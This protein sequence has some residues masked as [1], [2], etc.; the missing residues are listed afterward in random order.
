MAVEHLTAVVGA[1]ISEFKRKMAEVNAIARNAAREITAQVDAN[2]KPFQRAIAKVWAMARALDG[3]TIRVNVMTRVDRFERDL[4]D[5]ASAIRTFGTVFQHMLGG[6][7]MTL[8]PAL[9][10]IIAGATAAI[11]TLGI[12][13]GVLFGSTMALVSSLSLALLGFVGLGVA[14]IPTISNIKS[15]RTEI[16]EGRRTLESYSKPMQRTLTGLKDMNKGWKDLNKAIEPMVLNAF[17]AGMETAVDLMRILEPGIKGAAEAFQGLM[18]SMKKVVNKSRDMSDNFDWF[19]ERAGQAVSNWG[20]IVGYAFRG[21]LN[22]MRSFDPLARDT[23]AGLLRMTK[24][25]SEWADGLGKSEKFK[26][27]MDYVRE[28][29]PKVN[30]IIGNLI[31]GTINMF[32]AFGPLAS[33]MLTGF[34]DMTARFV[35]W[36]AALGENQ[37]FQAFVNY[38]RANGPGVID[39]IGNLTNF[40]IE[41][42]K[43]MAPLGSL[44]LK[45]ANA[46]LSWSVEM[47]R[48]HPIIGQFIAVLISAMGIFRMVVPVIIFFRTIFGGLATAIA[49]GVV[50]ILSYLPLLGVWFNKIFVIIGRF[51]LQVASWVPFVVGLF[52]KLVMGIG[53]WFF[54]LG[55]VIWEALAVLGTVFG[56]IF[57]RI[58]TVLGS[59]FS[60]IFM[61]VGRAVAIIASYVPLV[62]GIIGKI[63]GGV[64]GFFGRIAWM[65]GEFVVILGRVLVQGMIWAGRMVAMWLIAMGPIGWIIAAVVA[66]VALIIWQWD[67]V[68]KYSIIAW[69]AVW[70]FLKMVWSK[71]SQAVSMAATLV[72]EYVKSKFSQAK[73]LVIS[74]W[75][76]ILSGLTN[77]INNIKTS[78][79]NGITNVVER[80]RSGFSNIVSSSISLW[81]NVVNAIKSAWSNIK[82]NVSSAISAVSSNVKSGWNNIKSNAISTWN[83]ITNAIKTAWNNIKSAITTAMSN[84]KSAIQNGFNAAKNAVTTAM[85]GILSAIKSAWN[86]AVNAVKSALSNMKSTVVNMMNGILSFI[87]GLG[88][89]FLS[90]GKGLIDMMARGITAGIGKVTGAVKN[91]AAK[92]RNFLPFSPAKVGPLSDLD[93]LD[94][95]GPITDS[96]VKASSLVKRQMGNMLTLPPMPKLNSLE[97]ATP[98]SNAVYTPKVNVPDIEVN[99]NDSDKGKQQINL[100]MT[101]GRRNFNAFVSDISETQREI[102]LREQREA[103][104]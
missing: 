96:I 58:A 1:R 99:N 62:V 16:A 36:S 71:I 20:K 5:L 73:E 32:A 94:F 17:G 92:V 88:S 26:K 90:A 34:K 12:A 13:I 55:T 82:S 66:L 51:A 69:T 19:N 9:V 79:S 97:V 104:R 72:V 43:G 68:K 47:M 76:Q 81:N 83:A 23:E 4:G 52:G 48:A 45:G 77:I 29:T 100:N 10:P 7:M 3:H 101:L 85:S 103:G 14:L 44:L 53:K 35:E 93:K 98:A 64:A 40:L 8:F 78:V 21:F 11:A 22:L 74:I 87:K 6:A 86:N 91:V 57:M 49:R 42:G 70:N 95:G 24:R 37:Q 38:I 61:I 59:F 54:M 89:S 25:F 31:K 50:V 75:N 28:N 65:L 15:A 63:V 84:V 39:L 67:T 102:E 80:V 27:F 60:N 2:T 18:E 46:F 30:S 41:L 33:D 56:Q